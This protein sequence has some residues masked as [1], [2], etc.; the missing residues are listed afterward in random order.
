MYHSDFV[1]LHLHSEYSLLDGACHLDR[2]ISKAVEYKMPAMAITDHG[3]MFAAIDF[4]QKAM[5]AGVKPIIGAELYVAPGSRFD[6]KK[7]NGKPPAFHIVLL[8]RNTAGYKN[9]LKLTTA[10][11][12]DGFYY[13]PRIDKELLA[14]HSD[15]LIALSACLKGEVAYYLL[16]DKD[17]FAEKA[18]QE[19]IDIFGADNF[20]IEIQENGLSEQDYVNKK[21][22]NLAKKYDLKPVATNDV[23]YIE[24][25]DAR[26]HEVLLCI[27]TQTTMRDENRMRMS[28]DMF[29]FASADEMKRRFKSLPEAVQ[30]T[31][32]VAQRCNLELE[33][34]KNHLPVFTPPNGVN[35]KD[36]LLSMCND[37]LPK[38]YSGDMLKTAKDRL[39]YEVSVIER[40]GYINYFLIVWDFIRYAKE[41]G[42]PSGPGRGS[43]AGSIVS[44]LLG[45]TSIDP[46]KYNLL[47]ERFLNPDRVSMPDIDIDFCY[48]N[49]QRVIDYV[50]E[51]YGR[52]NV[53]QIITFGT[54]KAR[55]VVRDVARALGLPYA[56]ADKIAKKIPPGAS[57]KE[58]LNM[59][60]ELNAM[61]ES[62]SQVKDLLDVAQ[63]LEGLT[64][65]ASTHAA[66]VVISDKPLIEYTPLF[67]SDNQVSTAYS[68]KPVEKIGLL[69]M[70]FLGLKTLTVIQHTIDMI[71]Q[72][73]GEE[74]DM[75]SIPLDD[76]AAFKLLGEAKTKGVFQLESSGMRDLLVRMQP[77]K[78]EDIIAL[79]ALYRPGPIGSGM[80]DDFIERRKGA[81]EVEYMLPELE[82]ILKE[83]YGVILYQEQVM[84][85]ASVMAGFSLAQA[86]LLRRAMGKKIPEEMEK[87]REAFINGAAKKNIDKKLAKKMF[88][89]IEYFSGYGFNKSHSAAYAVVSYRTAYLKANYTKE[90]M[91]ALLTSEH[92]N[93]DKMVDYIKDIE[94]M[95]IKILAPDVNKSLYPFTVEEG[96]VRFGLCA[97]K[98]VGEGPASAIVLEREKNGPFKDMMDF[99]VR[100]SGKVNKK[101]LEYL[102]KSSAFDGFGLSRREMFERI[103]D[104][105]QIAAKKRHEIDSGQLSL[106]ASGGASAQTQ[107]DN[108]GKVQEWEEHII[109]LYE[110]ESLGMYLSGHP[111]S[112][113]ADVLFHLNTAKI[114]DALQ[115]PSETNILIAGVIGRISSKISKRSKEKMAFFMLEDL[116]ADIECLTFPS[117]YK[118]VGRHISENNVVI[119]KGRI[120]AG[121]NGGKVIVSKIWD[122]S[123]VENLIDEVKIDITLLDKPAVRLLRDTLNG[124]RGDVPVLF[125]VKGRHEYVEFHPE[126]DLF[127]KPD[128]S[129]LQDIE[130]VIGN[131]KVILK[132]GGIQ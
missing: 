31:L 10:G 61:Y 121:E 107:A 67:K 58:A 117:V 37:A 77:D 8:C 3:N 32:E 45:I 103:D 114:E 82:P 80:L 54:M 127:V 12:F 1:H 48:E 57:L 119:V 102:I 15:G 34:G 110:K 60:S 123:S 88:E 126:R 21:L 124:H 101:V 105:I 52:D 91:A 22:V 85:I 130:D 112:K 16:R 92:G 47:F 74:I 116:S 129:F 50:V 43:A 131:E 56:L 62:D 113:Y 17:D 94:S 46:L 90:F 79:L 98:N 96:A 59:D 33:F 104:Y 36:Y 14:R 99:C 13:Y 19:Y 20:Y 87:Q 69:K 49:R 42:I 78:F 120:D 122:I 11:F 27:Q 24:R 23:H 30:N 75:D 2:V 108:N 44:Y 115:L 84:Q 95:G 29:Y 109:L 65:H 100:L 9:L 81:K 132:I 93:T 64:R 68:M 5:K 72:A 86:D 71:K 76:E 106:F 70:D 53:A 63:V 73:T 51:K 7:E 125:Y 41:N 28:S 39:D 118:D 4:Y 26:A 35:S 6:K 89:L 38:R 40:M 66:G 83:T 55:A 18:L 111:L 97:I 128:F 25:K